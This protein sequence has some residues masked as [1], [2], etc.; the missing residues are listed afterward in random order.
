MASPISANQ[1][2]GLNTGLDTQGIIEKMIAV[3]K[4]HI[5]PVKVR[6]E[7]KQLE[8]DTWKQVKALLENVEK[9]SG[10]LS[11]R[12]MWEGKI[13]TSS[14]PDIVEATATSGAKPGKYT[15]AVDKLALNHQIASQNFET[16]DAYIG[17]GTIRVIIGEGDEQTITIDETNNT[18]QGMEDAINNSDLDMTASIIQTGNKKKPY[19]LVLTSKKTGTEGEIKVQFDF[20]VSEEG[21]W[22]VPTFDSYYSK[23]SKWK[24][25]TKTSVDSLTP[26]GTGAST[27]IPEFIGTYSG[28]EQ[29][30]IKFT[31]VNTG[32][33]GVAE[34][35][36]LRWEDNLGRTGYVDLGSFNYAPGEPID[37]I[38]GIQ[39]IMGYGEIIVNDSFTVGAKPEQ[40]DLLWWVSPEDRP[41]KIYE[42]TNWSRQST[43][44]APVVEGN[45]QGEDDDTYTM[46]ISGTGQVGEAED[47]YVEYSSENGKTGR[48]FIGRGYEPGSKLSLGDGLELSLKTGILQDGDFATFDVEPASDPNYWWLDDQQLAEPGKVLNLT[49]WVTPE[50]GDETTD[51][52][53]STQK[54]SG[55]RR[56]N[57]LKQIT[58]VY[59]GNESKVYTFTAMGSGSVGFTAGLEMKWEDNKGNSGTFAIGEGYKPEEVQRFDA[60]LSI[61]F[62]KGQVFEGDSFNM[63]AYS[64]VI[65]PA[66]DA[67]VRLGATDL[68]GGLLVTNSRNVLEEVIDGVKLNLLATGEKPVTINI[69]GDTEKGI[70]GVKSFVQAYNELLVFIREV[71]KYEKDSGESGPLQGDRNLPRIQN[72]VNNILINPI[73][74]LPSDRNILQVAG[75]KITKTGEVELEEEK[76]KKVIEEDFAKI[77]NLFRSYGTSENS[78]ITYLGSTKATKI[79][80]PDGYKLDISKAASRGYYVTPAIPAQVNITEGFSK[81][82]IDMNGRLSDEIVLEEG[83]K[84]IDELARDL[85]KKMRDDARIGKAKFLVAVE[86]GRI[87]IRSQ[88]WGER[89]R[90]EITAG[91]GAVMT[92]H[93]LIAGEVVEGTNI[94]GTID[95]VELEGSGQ[96]LSGKEGTPYEGLKLYS[97]LTQ[98][99]LS[100]EKEEATM[101][102]TKGVATKVSEYIASVTDERK[103]SLSI[104]TDSV[105][106][107]F[108]GYDDQIKRMNERVERKRD[109][110]K[111]KYARMEAQLGQLKSQQNYMAGQLSKLG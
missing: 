82:K 16:K 15:L 87:V 83:T 105:K 96:I 62:G 44:G 71:T 45:F 19:Q 58:G 110:L 31:G 59:S 94:E 57:A 34:N 91:E 70:E 41:S 76:L 36:Q 92:G 54:A 72:E 100:D 68:G 6:K 46:R 56:S 89:S 80:G 7:E 26:T 8:L 55:A 35:L 10:D 27:A 13:V 106:E 85:E 25:I 24:G 20:P 67:E 22:E 4:K 29:L 61:A 103:G 18:L 37:I 99:Q 42:P 66:Q 69:K 52:A 23:A 3:E 81:I 50:N 14:H 97:T 48:V 51:A 64:P 17:Q 63:R 32:I 40:S 108:A 84:T 2:G 109:N 11:K 78:G 43:A 30:E 65:Q 104:Y 39:M 21:K 9:A 75:V 74:G 28:E 77:A 5:E 53:D 86:E 95:G 73:S 88:N 90:V 102:F 49:S 79:S 93:P 1:V 12:S 47:L 101:V 111:M 38:D 98:S 107:Q 60:G 33:V